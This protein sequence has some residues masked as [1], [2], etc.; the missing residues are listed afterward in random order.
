MFHR[1]LPVFTIALLSI[2][3]TVFSDV[4]VED[5]E[6][7]PVL[8]TWSYGTGLG[9]IAESGG[10]PGRYFRDSRL[11]AFCPMICQSRGA[12]APP[13]I[14]FR[15]FGISSAGIDLI[16]HQVNP[17]TAPGRMVSLSLRHDNG[18]PNDYTDDWGAAYVGSE[19]I[20]TQV[21]VWQSYSFDIPCDYTGDGLPAGWDFVQWGPR[22]PESGNWNDI[23]TSVYSLDFGYG[24]P[25]RAFILESWDVGFDNVTMTMNNI[26]EPASLALLGIGGLAL[27]RRR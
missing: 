10:N 16:Q 23:I 3:T 21:G 13:P 12:I 4:F 6:N 5:Y 2:T 17:V 11:Q 27:M 25:N 15:L 24:D 1:Y 7:D 26:P 19:S 22:A 9:Y 8:S 14:N 20:P 18:T